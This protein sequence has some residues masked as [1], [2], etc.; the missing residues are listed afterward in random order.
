MLLVCD[1]VST[2]LK[3]AMKRLKSLLLLSILATMVLLASCAVTVPETE[4]SETS[5]AETVLQTDATVSETG[6]VDW[7]DLSVG[8]TFVFGEYGENE[9][10]WGILNRDGD[11]VTAVCID[12]VTS[13]PYN[14]SGG[15]SNWNDC[16]LRAWLNG[17]FF[18][19]AFSDDEKSR[20]IIMDIPEDRYYGVWT[21]PSVTDI[22]TVPGRLDLFDYQDAFNNIEFSSDDSWCRYNYV[23]GRMA[24]LNRAAVMNQGE[25]DRYR[26]IWS[27]EV[28]VRPMITLTFADNVDPYVPT[29]TSAPT[30]SPIPEYAYVNHRF[31]VAPDDIP[32]VDA[33]DDGIYFGELIGVSEDGTYGRFLIGEPLGLSP[34]FV[35]SLEAGDGI[36][37]YDLD[38]VEITIVDVI[39]HEDGSRYPIIDDDEFF[40]SGQYYEYTNEILICAPSV[41]PV[42]VNDVYVDL[43]ISSDCVITDSYWILNVEDSVYDDWQALEPSGVPLMDSFFWYYVNHDPWVE[44]TLTDGWYDARALA[45]P[46]VVSNGEVTVLN[47]EWR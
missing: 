26:Y 23:D 27:T 25:A 47:L 37:I 32:T 42:T 15:E 18:E 29:P 38:G 35:Y 17:E 5:A 36:G 43:P 7:G 3:I 31:Y 19:E 30:P 28:G 8:D 46:V 9:L 6:E 40:L 22:V 41:N 33:V 2:D 16:S 39:E 20:L 13:M 12:P 14:E 21:C 24:F 34:E 11:V 1:L 4:T 10:V 44:L 45:Y